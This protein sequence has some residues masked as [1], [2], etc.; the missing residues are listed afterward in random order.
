MKEILPALPSTAV[1]QHATAQV[2][3]LQTG[4]SIL[5]RNFLSARYLSALSFSGEHE[6]F[7]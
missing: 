2:A 5:H 1:L 3:L 6:L 4:T 7:R